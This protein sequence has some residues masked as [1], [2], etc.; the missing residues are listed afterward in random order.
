MSHK[1]KLYL[2]YTFAKKNHAL[3][4]STVTP[5]KL[6][7]RHTAQL[8][9]EVLMEIHRVTKAS[10]Q[11]ECL[12]ESEFSDALTRHYQN[13]SSNS[14]TLASHLNDELNLTHLI[15]TLPN[16]QD[17]LSQEDD[18]PIIRLINALFSEAI[19]GSASDLHIE[20]YEKKM[21]IRIRTDGIL[22]EILQLDRTLSPLIV[23]RIKVMAQ[24]DIAEKRL[25]QDGRIALNL[26]GRLIDV[27]VS[28]MPAN[29]SERVVLRILDKG[30][31]AFD[32][33]SL[34]IEKDT[35]HAIRKLI[36]KP[37]GIIL[38]TGPTG[39]GKTTT[40]Y[41][42]LSELNTI[43]RNI[44]TIED[45]IEYDLPGIGQTQVNHKIDMSFAKG[46]RAILRQDPDI[47][48]IGEIRD[49]ETA[50]IATQAAL[51]GHLV[52]STLHTNS[53]ANAI[54]RLQ[55]LGIQPFL[56]STSLLGVIA[57]RLV[58]KLCPHC[59][60]PLAPDAP[61]LEQMNLVF[62][63]DFY[64]AMGCTHC[65]SSGYKGRMGLYETLILN[66]TL[67]TMI[68]QNAGEIAYEALSQKDQGSLRDYGLKLVTCGITSLDEIF[69]VTH[70][71]L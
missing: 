20:T 50:E 51:T 53:A 4:Q 42:M 18:A 25:P 33:D 17:I 14:A 28:T 39:S 54:T 10:L 35:M 5:G 65:Q 36:K 32:F 45:P 30:S 68:G 15:D 71:I 52:L 7:V 23:S 49:L 70:Q 59:K 44:L 29:Y 27:R 57:Q 67:Q 26:A 60:V 1:T 11:L 55:D 40:L 37:H 24:L 21:V 38:I 69:R 31:Q 58:R 22:K 9:P 47:V 41:A 48:M 61:I 64:K 8:T 62:K 46:L 43:E 13:H 2:S 56:L 3:C 19:R 66:K 63:P 34:D 16:T 6:L 12:P